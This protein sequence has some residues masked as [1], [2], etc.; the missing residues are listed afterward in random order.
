MQEDKKICDIYYEEMKNKVS[1]ECKHELCLKCFM[2]IVD[3]NEFTCHMC[4]KK[5]EIE[6]KPKLSAEERLAGLI[7]ELSDDEND[8]VPRMHFEDVMRS[9]YRCFYSRRYR[10]R[11]IF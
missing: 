8:D 5:Y 6:D 10:N 2:K 11:S 9:I 4:R 1:L 7:I 3:D